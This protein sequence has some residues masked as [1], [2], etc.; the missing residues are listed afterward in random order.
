MTSPLLSYG[1]KCLARRGR[2]PKRF[3]GAKE[4]LRSADVQPE[5]VK[6][7]LSMTTDPGD[8]V[9]DPYL[10][11]SGT[12]CIRGR[13]TGAG[14]GSPSTRLASALALARARVMGAR[15]PYY[16]LSDSRDGQLR[17]AEIERRAPSKAPT[18]Q[19]H[20]TG[21]RLRARTPHHAQVHRQQRRDRRDLG[22][23]PGKCW[24]RCVSNINDA[25]G[26]IL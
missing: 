16:L 7:C 13:T 14:A 19:Q 4:I 8:L 15:Y 6:R 26:S 12:T 10:R 9:L 22:E 24:S 11:Q 1:I 25:L 23:I 18:H 2:R 5:V 17:E 20:P 3:C 21:I